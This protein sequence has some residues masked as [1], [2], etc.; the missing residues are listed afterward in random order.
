MELRA[1]KTIG[2]QHYGLE[3]F[4]RVL[5]NHGITKL[6]DVRSIPYGQRKEFD[7]PNLKAELGDRYVWAGNK[8]GGKGWPVKP[9]GYQEGIQWLKDLATTDNVCVMCMESDAMKCHRELWIAADLRKLGINVV[10]LG[11]GNHVQKRV[12]QTLDLW[13]KKE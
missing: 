2:Y 4:L 13:S 9:E 1:V 7:R 12:D 10:H 6:V 5:N 11:N 3:S 8:L